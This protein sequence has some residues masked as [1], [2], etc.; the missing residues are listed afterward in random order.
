MCCNRGLYYVAHHMINNLKL[1]VPCSHLH[2]SFPCPQLWDQYEGAI[3]KAI[4]SFRL[5]ETTRDYVA[6][7][8]NPWMFF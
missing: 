6:P 8:E 4:A 3:R 7:N 2:F 1:D 5:E